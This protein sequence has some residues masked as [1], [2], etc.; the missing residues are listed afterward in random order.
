MTWAVWTAPATWT[1]IFRTS[2]IGNGPEA[3]RSARDGIGQYCMTT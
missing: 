1:P 3:R 2:S